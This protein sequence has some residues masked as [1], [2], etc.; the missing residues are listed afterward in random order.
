MPSVKLKPGA[1]DVRNKNLDEFIGIEFDCYIHKE[2]VIV[3]NHITKGIH[4]VEHKY[5]TILKD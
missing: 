1:K 5:V 3:R 2:I 4:E